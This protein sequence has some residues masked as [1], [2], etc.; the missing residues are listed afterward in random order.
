MTS[1]LLAPLFY[2]VTLDCTDASLKDCQIYTS[3]PLAE[4]RCEVEA[5]KVLLMA[6]TFQLPG[7]VLAFCT[8]NLDDLPIAAKA[9]K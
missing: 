7:A 5:D 3:K 4:K 8:D 9:T 2:L 6:R 1:S